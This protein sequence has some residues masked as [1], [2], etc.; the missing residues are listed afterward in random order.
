MGRITFRGDLFVFQYYCDAVSFA[1]RKKILPVAI[2]LHPIWGNSIAALTVLLCNL[3]LFHC[4]CHTIP[5]DAGF[6]V[7]FAEIVCP[8]RRG[9]AA[10]DSAENIFAS[11][12]DVYQKQVRLVRTYYTVPKAPIKKMDRFSLSQS[13][14]RFGLR[15]HNAW[16][17]HTTSALQKPTVQL[18]IYVEYRTKSSFLKARK[19]KTRPLAVRENG[20][21][22]RTFFKKN[23][24]PRQSINSRPAVLAYDIVVLSQCGIYCFFNKVQLHIGRAGEKELGC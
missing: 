8:E 21:A 10:D 24:G 19:W 7:P 3:L 18:L 12:V 23:I 15:A 1:G 2:S 20:L 11:S 6:F 9:A 22:N 4:S 13:F 16:K 5:C 17:K 14:S